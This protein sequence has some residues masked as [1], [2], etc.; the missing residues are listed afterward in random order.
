[1]QQPTTQIEQLHLKDYL[2]V[3]RRRIWLILAVFIV[4]SVVTV[5]HL[6]R[7][8]PIYQA[9]A[10]L[11]IEPQQKQ[12]FISPGAAELVGLDLE[13]QMELIKMSPV[14]GQVV[15][16][17]GLS[18]AP[19]ESPKFQSA[20]KAL[21]RSIS[22]GMLRNTKIINITAKHTNPELARDIANAV[23]QAYINQ[24]RL[25][26]LQAGRD[27]VRWLSVQLAD[28]KTKLQQ[29]EQAFQSFKE[30]EKMVSLDY[31]R[32]EEI[33]ELSKL[34]ASYTNAQMKRLEV[35]MTLKQLENAS[36]D[37]DIPVAALNSPVM[38]QLGSELFRLQA[39]LAEK[40]KDFKDTYPGIIELKSK[41]ELTKQKIVAE[42]EKQHQALKSQEQSFLNL[43]NNKRTQALTLG[44]REME[45]L[46][47]EREVTTNREMY[48][49]LLTRI[50]E[51][52]LVEG[53]EGL[54]HIRIVA[55]AQ[56]PTRLVGNKTRTLMFGVL[57]G[58]MLGIGAA[59]FLEYLQ[60]S[61][62]TPDD[63]SRYLDQK[64]LGLIPV[65][66]E[67]KK[68]R[69]PTI[70]V[71]EANKSAPADAYRSLRT[72]L[73]FSSSDENNSLHSVLL[74]STGPGEGKS[75]TAVNLGIALAY[76]GKNVLLVDADLRKPIL[77]RVFEGNKLNGLSAVLEKEISLEEAITE[78][79]IPNLSVLTSGTVPP[80]PS[81]L[82]GSTEMQGL[83]ND[84][85]SSYDIVLIDSAPIL[86]MPDTTVLAANV[87]ATIL[88]IRAG[89]VARKPARI[90]LEQLSQV[91]AIP[92]GVVLNNVNFRKGKYYDYYYYYYYSDYS[93]E[94]DGEETPKKKR[95]KRR[96]RRDS[97]TSEQPHITSEHQ[98]ET[99]EDVPSGEE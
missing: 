61:I 45:Y 7:Q 2:F 91:N 34:N 54:N 43:L 78:T 24:D 14:L 92:L 90:A 36:G 19:P 65:A 13:T 64:V 18:T 52:S 58:L 51:L 60:T 77:H 81:E 37:I 95:G 86:G 9:R 28:I 40:R 35:E 39:Q 25:S 94:E 55:L 83:L 4:V 6:K 56:L 69:S 20:V 85:S 27:T 67:A 3:L 99:S 22:L 75:L 42:L 80:N 73:L 26:R 66:D 68:S 59:F 50:K 5:L 31:K 97:Q 15:S 79:S 93:A 17:L 11:V 41:V 12:D 30:R 89:G 72:N 16:Q 29:A 96:K 62:Q 70:L 57:L 98:Q 1:M 47:L 46:T 88:I 21:S 74:T 49:T 23:A 38:E 82:L 10:S 44:K 87:D 63:V 76:A 71:T 48:N 53:K 33:E 84:L 32:S 8:I